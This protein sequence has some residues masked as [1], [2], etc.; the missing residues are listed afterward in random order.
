MAL[1]KEI[2]AIKAEQLPQYLAGLGLNPYQITTAI[3][4]IFKEIKI[5]NHL[6]PKEDNAIHIDKE[7]ILK[8]AK[9]TALESELYSMLQKVQ[10]TKSWDVMLK[11]EKRAQS[12]SAPDVWH[13]PHGDQTIESKTA[14]DGVKDEIEILDFIK[15]LS[16]CGIDSK[17]VKQAIE[18]RMLLN[19]SS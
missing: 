7:A 14:R 10:Q 4:G 13:N 17:L 15:F 8:M 1:D 5:L 19:S 2:T 12:L 9:D 16:L 11:K 18:E 6:T 3:Y